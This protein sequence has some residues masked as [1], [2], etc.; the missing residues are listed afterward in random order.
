MRHLLTTFILFFIMTFE[1]EAQINYSGRVEGGYQHYLFRTITVD[2]GPN[3]KGYYL[4]KKQ[5]GFSVT[6][7]NGLVFAKRK[8]FTGIGL[9]YLN[10]EG[11]DGISIFGDF[12]Y[13]PLKNRVS[14]LFDLRLGYNHIWNQYENGTGT[15]NAEF[16]LGINYRLTEKLGL[17]CKSGLLITQQSFLIP[18]TL[19]FRF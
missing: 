16:G 15:M 9:G 4:D 3:W 19:G 11:I 1:T 12:E 17:Y 2:P 13:L 14:P 18:I 6:S 8:I 7:V 5:S 10:F